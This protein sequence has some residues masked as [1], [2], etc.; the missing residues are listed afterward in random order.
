MTG[1][2]KITAAGVKLAD[3]P[4][5]TINH[6]WTKDI[7]ASPDGTKLYATVGSNSNVGENGIE[8]EKDRADVSR[9][10]AQAANGACSPPACAIRTARRGNRRAGS[11]G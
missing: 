6:H 1:D 4:A 7:T 8:A 9:S 5:G 3:L 10:I 2:T 11:S